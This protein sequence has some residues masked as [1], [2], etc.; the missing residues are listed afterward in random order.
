MYYSRS[1]SSLEELKR[2]VT[3]YIDYYN[4][5]RFHSLN[6]LYQH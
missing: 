1:F 5:H 6:F 3:N 4:H 2:A